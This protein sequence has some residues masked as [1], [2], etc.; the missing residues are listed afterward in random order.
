MSATRERDLIRAECGNGAGA[1]GVRDEGG[2]PK[3]RHMQEPMRQ[4]VTAVAGQV[5]RAALAV[6]TS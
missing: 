3:T 4:G 6:A 5:E 1:A 2:A